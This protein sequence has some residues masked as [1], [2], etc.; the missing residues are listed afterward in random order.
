M[1]SRHPIPTPR[2]AALAA[3][4]AALLFLPPG[5]DAR[6]QSSGGR[7]PLP[8][9]IGPGMRDR[10]MAIAEME[11]TAGRP[12]VE[13]KQA[14]PPGNV[15]EDFKRIQV[16]NNRM[17]AGVMGSDSPD[18]GLVSGA[19]EEIRKRA[20]RLKSALALPEP[21]AREGVRDSGYRSPEDAA[22]LKA[23]LLRLDR[24]LMSFV[25]N[26]VFRN[27]GV[28]NAA[29]GA[30]AGRDLEE[31]IE[32]SRLINRDAARIRKAARKR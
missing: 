10:E 7:Q 9:A 21:D 17:M 11:R 6:A 8:E 19:T 27:A 22:Q 20:A 18:Y 2:A 3:L 16:A 12:P 24:A 23:A 26:P 14:L 5:R 30:K 13:K 25:N 31:V 4:A 29:D 1:K 28:V 32:L 15:A